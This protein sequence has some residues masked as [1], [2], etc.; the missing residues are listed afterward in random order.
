MQKH[1]AASPKRTILWSVMKEIS[2][3]D[4]GVLTKQEREEKT[5]RQTVRKYVDASGKQRFVGTAD[6]S[7]S[8]KLG[9]YYA[10]SFLLIWLCS[11]F[12]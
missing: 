5:T 6:L 4:L 1:G 11:M 9:P 12:L 7:A 2:M 3:L 8:Q 10:G